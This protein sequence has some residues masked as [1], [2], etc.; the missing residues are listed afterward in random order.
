MMIII[1]DIKLGII[2]NWHIPKEDLVITRLV[3]LN[4]QVIISSKKKEPLENEYL[5]LY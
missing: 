1:I 5:D 4:T 3:S 2:E